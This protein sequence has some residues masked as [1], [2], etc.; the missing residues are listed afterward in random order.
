MAEE[1]HGH[2]MGTACCV[3]FGLKRN[4]NILWNSTQCSEGNEVVIAESVL[5]LTSLLAH[6]RTQ[7]KHVSKWLHV[8]QS[9]SLLLKVVTGT[10]SQIHLFDPQKSDKAWNCITS[11][12][13]RIRTP[14][15]SN[16]MGIFWNSK[17]WILA[18]FLSTGEIH[19]PCNTQTRQN[20]RCSLYNYH[21]IKK[22]T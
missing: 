14:W 18:D 10:E 17:R 11:H 19:T 16:V 4:S 8:A 13:Q 9:N 22:L 3:W 7:E 21:P 2:G 1:R 20:L 12:R 6:G 5:P 15:T